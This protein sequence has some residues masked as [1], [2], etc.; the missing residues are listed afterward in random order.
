VPNAAKK[1]M[2]VT[3]GPTVEPIDP[4]RFISNYSTGR[5]GYEIAR[6]A[7]RA[8]FDVCLVSGPVSLPAPE[9]AEVISVTTAE[10][11]EEKLQERLD[12]CACLVMSAAVCDFRPGKR[13]GSKIKKKDALALELVRT[14]D[15]LKGIGRRR[16][17]LKVG[18][19]LETEDALTNGLGKLKDK[20]L[21]IVVINTKSPD[22]EVFGDVE[23][24]YTIADSSGRVAETE[25]ISKGR[26]AG[27]LVEKVKEM[28]A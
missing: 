7:V 20:A 24:S 12:G 10:E 18:F 21:D 16:G 6:E 17:M 9:G 5:M 8:G 19:A 26:L 25:K 23:A 3:A 27:I 14:P 1:K 2:I 13:E 4:V 28:V 22:T 11:M 15:I